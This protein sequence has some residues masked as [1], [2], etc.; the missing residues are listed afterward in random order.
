MTL[1]IPRCWRYPAPEIPRCWRYCDVGAVGLQRCDVGDTQIL[2]ILSRVGLRCVAWRAFGRGVV[3]RVALCVLR[4]GREEAPLWRIASCVVC[5]VLLCFIKRI[6]RTLARAERQG[7]RGHLT[8]ARFPSRSGRMFPLFSTRYRGRACGHAP[9]R[10]AVH[11][12]NVK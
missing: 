6:P 3:W 9:G 5:G 8:A 2:K 10:K 4:C 11:L 7:R 12:F 1:D